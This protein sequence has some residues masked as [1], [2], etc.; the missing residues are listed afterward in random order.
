MSQDAILRI[1]GSK[2]QHGSLSKRVYLMH[3]EPEDSPRVLNHMNRLAGEN[4]YTKLIAKIPGK[5]A[6]PFLDNGFT[7]EA[8][9]P[10]FFPDGDSV[11]FL[12]KFLSRE[13]ST[14][15]NPE[16]LSRVLETARE[17]AAGDS[18]RAAPEGFR[19]TELGRLDTERMATLYSKVFKTY[20]FPIFDP[21]YLLET[22]RENFRYFGAM[23]GNDLAAAASC[24][25]DDGCVEMTDFATH[26]DYQSAGLA[27]SILE[28]MEKKMREENMKTSFT[29]A[30][31]RSFGINILF[32]RA[33]YIFAG[34]LIN[35]TGISGR[36]ESMNVWYKPLAGPMD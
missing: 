27:G 35:N 34:T 4:G 5:A 12:A 16:R 8:E 29:I 14:A 3:L 17:K 22:M 30:R 9:I 25:M 7:P 32:S 20:P 26:P 21:K 11:L 36:M 19:F 33:A 23:H 28:L 6:A 13:R 2:L 10:D 31:S 1:G 15:T 18:G 24:E